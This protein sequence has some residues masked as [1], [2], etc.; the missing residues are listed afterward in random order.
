MIWYNEVNEEIFRV[1]IYISIRF[2]FKDYDKLFSQ[3]KDILMKIREIWV[4][5]FVS[6]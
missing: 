3:S 1:D 4:I 5:N 2:I 6:L